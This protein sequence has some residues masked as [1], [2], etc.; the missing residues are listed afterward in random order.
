VRRPAKLLSVNVGLPRE[1]SWRGKTVLTSIWKRPVEGR[2]GV[3][4][5]NV[6]GDRQSDLEVHGGVDKAVYAYPSEHYPFWRSV[7]PEMDRGWGALGENLTT[8]GLLE[9]DVRSGDLLGIGTV[10]LRVTEPRMPC[11]KLGIRF[12][13]DDVLKRML[14]SAFTG[15]YLAVEREGE[16]SAGDGIEIVSRAEDSLTMRELSSLFAT[17]RGNVERLRRAAG[18]TSLP[19]SL[20]EYFRKR[21]EEAE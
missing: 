17:D 3:K 6:D 16:L 21:L 4:L 7:A 12:G 19:E 10:V 13:R 20:R 1:V 2:V 8:E 5:L 9:D 14:E 11:F 18:L 15:F